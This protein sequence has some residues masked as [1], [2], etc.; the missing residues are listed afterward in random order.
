MNSVFIREKKILLNKK[1]K[2]QDSLRG[3]K[4]KHH[5]ES[6]GGGG[7][8]K[9]SQHL[10]RGEGAGRAKQHHKVFEQPLEVFSFLFFLLK[11]FV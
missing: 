4:L 8:S 10:G 11:I 7:S 6:Q 9:L 5:K 3:R 1:Y 2:P